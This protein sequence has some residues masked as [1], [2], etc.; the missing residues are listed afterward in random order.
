MLEQ[1]DRL[2]RRGMGVVMTTHSPTML[3][4]RGKVALMKR[5]NEFL[6]GSAED[7]VTE[8]NLRSAYGVD[9]KITDVRDDSGECIKT[10]IP[11]LNRTAEGRKMDAGREKAN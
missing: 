2:V 6:F 3:S 10:C 1:V 9:V 5:D 7:I 8:E 4:C 11:V